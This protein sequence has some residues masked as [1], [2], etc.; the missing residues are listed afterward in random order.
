MKLTRWLSRVGLSVVIVTIGFATA[1][2]DGETSNSADDDAP[3][4]LA[5]CYAAGELDIEVQPSEV[6]FGCDGTGTL[7]G[8]TWSAWGASGADG[9]GSARQTLC[10]PSCAAGVQSTYPV[11]VHAEDVKTTPEKCH[12]KFRY[13][14]KLIVAYPDKS[15]ESTDS[16]YKGMPSIEYDTTPVCAV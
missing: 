7:F 13:F 12:V 11:V 1:C 3:I 10:E 8:M 16:T 9:A 4:I 5:R 15:P 14:S 2:S 6:P